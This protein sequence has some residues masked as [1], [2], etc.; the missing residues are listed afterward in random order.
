L[1]SILAQIAATAL[2]DMRSRFEAEEDVA[3]AKSR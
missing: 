2:D 3:L 1:L